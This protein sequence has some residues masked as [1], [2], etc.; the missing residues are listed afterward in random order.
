MSCADEVLRAPGRHSLRDL[1]G[2][3]R[4]RW[5]HDL[6]L[7][8]GILCLAFPF[9]IPAARVA[10]WLV[11]GGLQPLA[12]P[13][14]DTGRVLPLWAIVYTFGIWLLIWS[15]TEEVTYQGYVLPR[16]EVLSQ[17]WIAVSIV[18]F[19]WALQHVFLPFILDWKYVAWRFLAFLP[20]M[21]VLTLLYLR[22][23]R[24]PPFFVAHWSMDTIAIFMTLKL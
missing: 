6:F 7:G 22:I 11:Y 5:G 13:G 2:R 10:S 20:S 1:I 8:A 3:I 16:I 18:S 14:L 23:R 21:I 12:F 19:W 24:L 15:P 9:F 17:R 4:L